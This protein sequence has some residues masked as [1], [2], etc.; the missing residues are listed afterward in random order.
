M[1]RASARLLQSL[2]PR[3]VGHSAQ[4]PRSADTRK[5]EDGHVLVNGSEM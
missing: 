5:G 1:V 3:V 4:R 2:V